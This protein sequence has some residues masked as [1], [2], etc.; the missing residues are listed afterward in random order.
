MLMEVVIGLLMDRV[1]VEEESAKETMSQCRNI[2][3]SDL[4]LMSIIDN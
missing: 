3:P 2:Y 1:D 4:F